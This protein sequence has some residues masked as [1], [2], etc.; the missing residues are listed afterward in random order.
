MRLLR[1]T[2]PPS[3]MF[4]FSQSA[5]TYPCLS[6]INH[7]LTAGYPYSACPDQGA[8]R[9]LQSFQQQLDIS[10]LIFMGKLIRRAESNSSGGS[11]S[12]VSTGLFLPREQA[13][14]LET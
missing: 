4:L 12:A 7:G 3:G 11:P 10:G 5:I 1:R 9:L 14:P 13:D 8:A 2:A 6:S